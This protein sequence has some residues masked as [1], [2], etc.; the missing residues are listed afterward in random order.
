MTPDDF[1]RQAD[2]VRDIPLEVVLTSWGAVRDQRDKSR[3]DT[4][5]GPVSVT[6]AKFYGW[7]AGEGGGGAIDLVMYLG[8]WNAKQAIQ[9]L[10]CHHGRHVAV[11]SP[12]PVIA[13]DFTTSS[14]YAAAAERD[15]DQ[16]GS[17][18]PLRLPTSSPANLARVCRY[19]TQQRGLSAVIVS[20]LID[21]GKLYADSRG[22]AVFLMVMGKP[23]RPVGAELRGTGSCTWRGLAPGSRRDVGYFWVGRVGAK[24]IVLCE[25]A[26]DAV[27]CFQMNVPLPGAATPGEYICISTAGVR[28]HAPWLPPLL[29][30]GYLIY[31]G[32]DTDEPG[33]VTS[34]HMITRYPTIERLRPPKHDWNDALR[35]RNE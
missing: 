16:R 9:W 15:P 3:W 8:D 30:R 5:R 4:A 32:F 35:A 33:E 7:Y 6:G 14:P 22:N 31:C 18:A 13:P 10:W 21:A 17:P 1:R 19:L 26:I 2:L 20:A 34:G 29:A 24:H 27:S 25:S 23:N 11:T 12:A 28:S